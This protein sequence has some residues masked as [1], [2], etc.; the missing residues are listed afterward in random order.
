[1]IKIDIIGRKKIEIDA[2]ICDFNGTIANNGEVDQGIKNILN[3]LSRDV[4]I[5]VLTADTYGNVRKKLADYPVIIKVFNGK[6]ALESKKE[7]VE[8]IGPSRCIC[9]G[10]GFNDFGM[11]DIAEVSIVIMGKEGF[12]LPLLSVADIGFKSSIDALEAIYNVKPIV[13]TLRG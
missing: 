11:L 10:N 5:Y 9:I 13:A 7:I 12:Y 8:E 2:I 1:M 4:E 6:S 3:K